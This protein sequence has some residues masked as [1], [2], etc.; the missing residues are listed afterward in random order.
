MNHTLAPARSLDSARLHLPAAEADRARLTPAARL[1]L[2]LGLWLLLRSARRDDSARDRDRRARSLAV[3]RTRSDR[4]HT[5]L[6]VHALGTVR[7]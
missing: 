1:E 3:D 4:Q 7:T 2:R 5:A 6:R